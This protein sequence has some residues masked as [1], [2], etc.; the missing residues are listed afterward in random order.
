MSEVS[1]TATSS[2]KRTR[3]KKPTE[4]ASSTRAKKTTESAASSPTVGPE[5]SLA[6]RVRAKAQGHRESV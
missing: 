5:L 4:S 2:P 1:N 3:T 6:E